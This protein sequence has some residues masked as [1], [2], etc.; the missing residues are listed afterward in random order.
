MTIKD[1]VLQE[2]LL[3]CF[4]KVAATNFDPI[5]ARKAFPCFDEPQLKA[6][7]SIKIS[8]HRYNIYMILLKISKIEKKKNMN[9]WIK[10]ESLLYFCNLMARF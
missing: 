8:H 2:P 6:K 9:T 10:L 3:S 5:S 7:F 4:S 1:S